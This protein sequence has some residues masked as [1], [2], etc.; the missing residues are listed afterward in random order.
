[1]DGAKRLASP[2]RVRER[3]GFLTLLLKSSAWTGY[4]T[5]LTVS[6][7]LPVK[8]L[9][10]RRFLA[11]PISL[12]LT[13]T[14]YLA[15]GT[16]PLRGGEDAACSTDKMSQDT[17]EPAASPAFVPAPPTPA[18]IQIWS[19]PVSIEPG[20][21]VLDSGLPPKLHLGLCTDW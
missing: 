5:S 4:Q 19:F 16:L 17:E 15:L 2:M 3:G 10:N 12:K 11:V 21:Q 6:D 20:K 9:V 8:T 18:C 13:G 7:P 14:Q 1:M